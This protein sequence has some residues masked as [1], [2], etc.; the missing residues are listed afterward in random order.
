MNKGGAER[1]GD[2]GSEAASR[3]RA[4]GTVPDARPEPVNREMMM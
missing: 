4:I 1:E 3:L 2:T